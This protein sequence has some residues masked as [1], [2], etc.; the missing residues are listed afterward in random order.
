MKKAHGA[1]RRWLK[2]VWKG[3]QRQAGGRAGAKEGSTWTSC[4]F[5]QG[6]S[7]A[8]GRR[9]PAVSAARTARVRAKIAEA[10]KLSNPNGRKNLISISWPEERRE[11]A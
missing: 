3:V 5:P 1:I 11:A 4:P 2:N 8:T 7:I 10:K 9:R 6:A